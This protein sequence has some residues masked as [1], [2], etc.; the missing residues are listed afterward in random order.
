MSKTFSITVKIKPARTGPVRTPRSAVFARK[1]T[2][3]LGTRSARSR[4]A[5]GE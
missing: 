1:G 2:R 3:R 5:I 4:K